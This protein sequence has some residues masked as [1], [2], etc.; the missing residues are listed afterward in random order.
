MESNSKHLLEN[1]LFTI[2]E[3]DREDMKAFHTFFRSVEK[4]FNERLE[5]RLHDHPAFRRSFKEISKT[6]RKEQRRKALEIQYEAIFNNNWESYI[7][8]QTQQGI[9]FALLGMDFFVWYDMIAMIRDILRPLLFEESNK[10]M[11]EI[12]TIMKGKSRFFDIRLCIIA[13]AYINE[14]KRIIEEQKRQL[15]KS[16]E[17]Q[18]Q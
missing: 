5:K 1:I 2:K 4:E 9:N 18:K 11:S 3:E 12:L 14:K 6:F 13:E 8:D 10:A 17:G 7:E 15:A 16:E